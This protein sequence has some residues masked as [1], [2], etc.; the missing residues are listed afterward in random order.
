LLFRLD[1]DVE[2]SAMNKRPAEI[3]AND[4]EI[5]TL[6][7]RELR[8]AQEGD[9][10]ARLVGYASVFNAWSEDLG[11]FR[12]RVQPGAF[13]NAVKTSDVRALINHDPSLILGRTKNGTLSVREDDTGL[14]MEVTLPDT[15]YARD[16]AE[17]VKRGDIDQM[18]FGFSVLNDDW[19]WADDGTI[20]RTIIEV[21][22][23]YD[24]SPVTYPAYPQTS[25]S[26]RSRLTELQA[27]NPNSEHQRA[28]EQEQGQAA[29]MQAER[30]AERQ[31]AQELMRMR[32]RIAEV[33]L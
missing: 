26:A 24:V 12:E 2:A 29:S 28:A 15:Q 4:R 17:S 3:A 19:V 11:G 21:D 33:E 16:L 13:G 27:G 10:P 32:L 31:A 23:L 8:V 9:A 22:R 25:V 7:V 5:R 20:R 18:S 14:W 6:P 1:N 30:E